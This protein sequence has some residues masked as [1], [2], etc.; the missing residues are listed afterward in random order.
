MRHRANVNLAATD[1]N[2]AL[3][4]AVNL[5][6]DIGTTVLQLLL[7]GEAEV[8]KENQDGCAPLIT[9]AGRCQVEAV[10]ILCQ[11]RADVESATE[12]GITPMLLA[13]SYSS[14]EVAEI[15]LKHRANVDRGHS[16]ID[17][18]PLHVAAFAGYAGVLRR[19]MQARAQIDKPTTRGHT[20]LH[21]AAWGGHVEVTQALLEG[22]ADKHVC[23]QNRLGVNAFFMAIMT[24]AQKDHQEVLQS[25]FTGGDQRPIHFHS[26]LLH[27]A[28][29]SGQVVTVT[30]LCQ[31][32]CDVNEAVTDESLAGLMESANL[33]QC[34]KPFNVPTI[35]A[36]EENFENDSEGEEEEG[37]FEEDVNCEACYVGVTP[38]EMDLLQLGATPLFLAAFFGHASLIQILLDAKAQI[39]KPDC[40]G[41]TPL[42][43]AAEEGMV[44]IAKL[45]CQ[46]KANLNSANGDGL[47]PLQVA[48]LNA[49]TRTA[50]ELCKLR[51]D[52]NH[53]ASEQRTALHFAASSQCVD[54]V[55]LLCQSRAN[56]DATNMH[57]HTALAISAAQG[58]ARIVKVL[59]EAKATVTLRCPEGTAL[60]LAHRHGH[61]E[62]AKILKQNEL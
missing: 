7:Q 62:V 17:A 9:A 58:N 22:G 15:L 6:D 1:G 36:L 41:C 53:A 11:K 37:H 12:K 4:A 46:K 35:V 40:R 21:Y 45:L 14:A 10:R 48:A 26:L 34:P 30:S 20:A 39:D 16:D 60:D 24:D 57:G 3:H 5:E 25:L 56:L 42:S 13:A 23:V 27:V 43:A 19:L 29:R 28:V 47:T 8:N 61:K 33:A 51:A 2:T 49:H 50:E 18:A 54:I 44:E 59:C 31:M 38:T 32:R 52:I 55:R